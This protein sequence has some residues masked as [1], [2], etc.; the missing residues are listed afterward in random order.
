MEK[1]NMTV[2]AINKNVRTSPR[3]LSLVW[4][5][6][7]FLQKGEKNLE[8]MIEST[9]ITVKKSGLADIGDKVVITAGLPLKVEGTTN[10]IRVTTIK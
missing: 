3:K 4:G 2:K 5:V 10:L 9:E 6:L 7:C 1:N 8:K